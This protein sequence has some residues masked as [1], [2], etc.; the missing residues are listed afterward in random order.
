[1]LRQSETRKA[2][3]LKLKKTFAV[4]LGPELCRPNAVRPSTKSTQLDEYPA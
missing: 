4:G 1:M 3:C 2:V